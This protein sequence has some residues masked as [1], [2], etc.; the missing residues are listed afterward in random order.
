M[1]PAPMPYV[2]ALYAGILGLL[3]V[4]L[5]ARVSASRRKFGV[6]LGDGAREP[7]ALVMR[8]HANAAEWTPIGLLLL[9]AAEL[10]RSSHV[11]LHAWGT[12]FAVARVA[13]AF[14]FSR[15]PG[16]SAGRAVGAALTYLLVALLALWDIVVFVRTA[17][18]V[19]A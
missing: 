14:G 6:G 16:P 5:G 8:V 3:L 19:G 4:V 18:A 1:N 13:H 11:L 10:N 17:L 7:L 12:A 2:T 9:L 15:S